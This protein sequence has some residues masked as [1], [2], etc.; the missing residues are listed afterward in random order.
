MTT[1]ATETTLPRASAAVVTDDTL[2][3]D[4]IDGRTV[5]VPLPGTRGCFMRHPRSA[6]NGS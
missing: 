6:A 1:S 3:V 4:L 5:S 2:T